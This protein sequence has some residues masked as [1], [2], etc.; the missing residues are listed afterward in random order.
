LKLAAEDG[1]LR[2]TDVADTEQLFRLNNL[3]HRQKRSL[4][5]NYMQ[6]SKSSPQR[7][8][9]PDWQKSHYLAEC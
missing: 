2:F 3:F 6:C 9:S 8:G 5:N 1:K 4:L 7:T